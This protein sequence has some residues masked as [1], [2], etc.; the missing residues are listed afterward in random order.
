MT[1]PLVHEDPEDSSSPLIKAYIKED[2]DDPVTQSNHPSVHGMITCSDFNYGQNSDSAAIKYHD[3]DNVD[4]VVGM[5]KNPW[6]YTDAIDG[7][8]NLGGS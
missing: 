1:Y 6:E 3:P 2:P 4:D 8:Y 7:V 5:D